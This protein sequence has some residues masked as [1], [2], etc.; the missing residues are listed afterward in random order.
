ME[1]ILKSTDLEH[2]Y[3]KKKISQFIFIWVLFVCLFSGKESAARIYIGGIYPILILESL[4]NLYFVTK[5][6]TAA[7][8]T[9]LLTIFSLK[10]R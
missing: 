2:T 5:Y 9:V 8:P 1:C 7:T 4:T 3:L 10:K 6:D